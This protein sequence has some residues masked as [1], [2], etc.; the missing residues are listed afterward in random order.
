MTDIAH[1]KF[2]IVDKRNTE[3]AAIV[4]PAVV[5][6]VTPA[7]ADGMVSV[8]ELYSGGLPIGAFASVAPN[9]ALLLPLRRPAR[10]TGGIVTA[11]D[12]VRG[13]LGTA[14]VAY[15]VAGV[16]EVMA[17]ADQH[18]QTW[19]PVDAGDVVVVRNAMLEPLHPDLEPLS[20]HRRHILA[21]IR[22]RDELVSEG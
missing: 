5:D 1:T 11:V 4:E 2:T 7:A 8:H 19:T 15:I 20:I 9:T 22:L 3:D 21:V 10:S 13:T 6:G 17:A 14:C 12:E 16:G 18:P